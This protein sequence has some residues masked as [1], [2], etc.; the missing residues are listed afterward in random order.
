ML[1][2]FVFF[3]IF[4]YISFQ[5]SFLF[6]TFRLL[7]AAPSRYFYVL[8]LV[9]LFFSFSYPFLLLFRLRTGSSVR[10]ESTEIRFFLFRLKFFQFA[11]KRLLTVIFDII[12]GFLAEWCYSR[13][14]WML[15]CLIYDSVSVCRN[16]RILFKSSYQCKYRHITCIYVY[17]CIYIYIYIYT[18]AYMYI[19][20]YINIYTYVFS[21]IFL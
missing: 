16:F 5:F 3:S 15:I 18:Y 17:V 21:F 20:M 10:G 4:L 2:Y 9:F 13:L 6:L 19:C 11:P 14:V 7:F 12:D 8:L 1:V